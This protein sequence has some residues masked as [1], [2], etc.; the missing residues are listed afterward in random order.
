V[1]D[2]T[3]SATSG[4]TRFCDEPHGRGHEAQLPAGSSATHAARTGAGQLMHEVMQAVERN[5]LDV[6]TVFAMHEGPRP[7]KDVVKLV[8]AALG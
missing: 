1:C 6:E 5:G 4:Q 8:R 7:W 2:G 3:R